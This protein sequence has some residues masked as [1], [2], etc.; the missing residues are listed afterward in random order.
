MSQNS[1]FT[2]ARGTLDLSRTFQR[3][4]IK[5]CIIFK[6]DRWIF[7]H[8]ANYL[9][10]SEEF[11]FRIKQMTHFIHP[12]LDPWWK[13]KGFRYVIKWYNIWIKRS[14]VKFS[15]ALLLAAKFNFCASSLL[16]K[17]VMN[18]W[19]SFAW[20]I[21]SQLY[22]VNVVIMLA[23]DLDFSSPKKIYV[24]WPLVQSIFHQTDLSTFV[25]TFVV[26]SIFI[27]I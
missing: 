27:L 9:S 12:C 10:H 13:N 3:D 1:C 4:S 24:I 23:E 22:M 25:A 16:Q 11:S 15:N 20:E 26:I 14:S 17:S 21:C 5:N 18:A 6:P 8:N 2:N 19:I 7:T